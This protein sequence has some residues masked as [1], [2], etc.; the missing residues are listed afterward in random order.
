MEYSE[1]N[2]WLES[3]PKKLHSAPHTS[4]EP[5]EGCSQKVRKL[6]LNPAYLGLSP[7]SAPYHLGDLGQVT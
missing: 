7:G 6:T 5:F 4:Y 3:G 2:P 1:D